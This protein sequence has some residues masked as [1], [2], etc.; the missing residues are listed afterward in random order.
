MGCHDK[1]QMEE[2]KIFKQET[3]RQEQKRREQRRDEE[4][5]GGRK[6]IEKWKWREDESGRESDKGG[7]ESSPG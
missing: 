4:I 1:K 5:L 2:I 6:R 3:Q 7:Q